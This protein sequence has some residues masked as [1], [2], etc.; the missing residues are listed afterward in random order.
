MITSLIRL[1]TVDT[2]LVIAILTILPVSRQISRRGPGVSEMGERGHS[3]PAK[4]NAPA[5]ASKLTFDSCSYCTNQSVCIASQMAPRAQ[6]SCF[7]NGCSARSEAKATAF[8]E[9]AD[10]P[11]RDVRAVRARR[12]FLIT[13]WLSEVIT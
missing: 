3:I 7:P 10:G 1:Q 8:L 9:R 4:W 12:T 2:H 5:A 6:H 11:T 13:V